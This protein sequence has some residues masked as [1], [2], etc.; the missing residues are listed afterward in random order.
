M[1]QNIVSSLRAEIGQRDEQIDN[2]K[3]NSLRHDQTMVAH[4]SYFLV[5]FE[6]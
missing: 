4:H 3:S 6:R 1:G 5:Y 2:L